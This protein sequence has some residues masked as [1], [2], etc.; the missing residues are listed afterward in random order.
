MSKRN[1]LKT[2]RERERESSLTKRGTA[3][4]AIVACLVAIALALT[5]AHFALGFN[6]NPFGKGVASAR[7]PISLTADS[8]EDAGE[9][10]KG[11]IVDFTLTAKY[12]AGDDDLSGL[13]TFTDVLPE[14]MELVTG[15]Q[16]V[17]GTEIDC[18]PSLSG[19]SLGKWAFSE[20]TSGPGS[21]DAGDFTYDATTRTLKCYIKDMVAVQDAEV[22]A[23]IKIYVKVT[24]DAYSLTPQL[25]LLY[26]TNYATVNCAQASALSNKIRFY[27]GYS[28]AGEYTLHY[29]WAGATGVG[30]ENEPP[31]GVTLPADVKYQ[32]S[33]D[34]PATAVAIAPALTHKG[35]RFEGW[36]IS[37]D[38]A[39]AG[40]TLT[41][42]GL[43]WPYTID[44]TEIT[45]VGKWTKITDT[46]KVENTWIGWD[47]T[48]G[49][50]SSA[51]RPG[52]TDVTGDDATE[53][54]VGSDVSIPTYPST[55]A[56]SSA[57]AGENDPYASLYDAYTFLGYTY[58]AAYTK[59]DV[60]TQV[61]IALT[62]LDKIA[63]TFAPAEET[64]AGIL[65]KVNIQGKWERKSFTMTFK[66]GAN[67]PSTLTLADF[68]GIAGGEDDATDENY[69]VTSKWGEKI[70]V[71]TAKEVEGGEFSHW[72]FA[73]DVQELT[74]L[75]AD[76]TAT[77]NMPQENVVVTGDWVKTHTLTTNNATFTVGTDATSKT[78]K[79]VAEG[80]FIT[81][82]PSEIGDVKFL[83]YTYNGT[84]DPSAAGSI[85]GEWAQDDSNTATFKMPDEDV[86]LTANMALK[87][88]FSIKNG[89]WTNGEKDDFELMLPV[90]KNATDNTWAGTLTQANVTATVGDVASATPDDSFDAD[91]SHWENETPG[92]TAFP[93][94]YLASD[95]FTADATGTFDP[96]K[97]RDFTFT[98]DMLEK[99]KVTYKVD[100]LCEGTGKVAKKTTDGS[101]PAWA[102]SWV[103]D[104]FPVKSTVENAAG[105]TTAKANTG[106]K[107]A[108]WVKETDW[109]TSVSDTPDF[110]PTKET[111]DSGEE[112][113]V[114]RT[115]C[116]LFSP[117]Q[118]TI[119]FDANGGTGQ[120][121]SQLMYYDD[122]VKISANAFTRDNY[123]F[124]G[125]NTESDGSGDCYADEQRVENL[126][127]EDGKEITLYAQWRQ[128]GN[129]E[130]VDE[131]HV[132]GNDIW[133]SV[134]EA[135]ELLDKT[136]AEK[137]AYVVDK[138][139]AFAIQRDNTA[140]VTKKVDITQADLTDV[141]A[142]I[143]D[144][145]AKLSTANTASA[146]IGVHVRTQTNVQEDENI[147]IVANNFRV[148]SAN[149]EKW[150]LNKG[151][152]LSDAGKQALIDFAKA[153]AWN[154]SDVN[155][156]YDIK[157]QDNKISS[158]PGVYDVTFK[159]ENGE[160]FTV[161]VCVQATVFDRSS[162]DEEDYNPED[163][164]YPHPQPSSP[165]DPDP[166][167]N[168]SDEIVVYANDFAISL[169]EASDLAGSGEVA[170][171]TVKERLVELAAAQAEWTSDRNDAEVAS[172]QSWIKAEKGVYVV[173][174][175]SEAD[176][177]GKTANV[178]VNAIVREAGGDNPDS[179]VDERITA[180]N[181]A[182]KKDDVPTFE[183]A[184]WID[185][186][187]A[188]A[189]KV[190]DLTGGRN[191]DITQVERQGD[192]AGSD[193]QIGDYSDALKFATEAGTS[194]EV[195]ARVFDEVEY[196]DPD[197][198]SASYVQIAANN[199]I[200]SKTQ[201]SYLGLD[202]NVSSMTNSA[203]E[204]LA[205]KARAS[206]W[207]TIDGTE[208]EPILTD[209]Q[210]KAEKGIY[211]VTFTAT[212]KDGARTA[213]VTVKAR[214]SDEDATRTSD[215]I[216]LYANNIFV[217]IPEVQE[218]DLAE[219]DG[220][221]SATGEKNL[222]EIAIAKAQRVADLKNIEVKVK[223]SDV[224]AEKGFY[225]VTFVAT[226]PDDPSISAEVTIVVTVLDSGTVEVEYGE[227]IA[228]NNFRIS[229]AEATS[230]MVGNVYD[231]SNIVRLA[232][233]E[234]DLN[235]GQKEL[236]R[237][238]NARA[239]STV[240]GA[241]VKIT[242]VENTLSASKGK[243]YTATF[244]TS[245]GTEVKEANVVV[246]DNSSESAELKTRMT[247][248]N[249]EL[250][251]DE[252][253]ELLAKEDAEIEEELIEKC[254]AYAYFTD[255]GAKTDV[256][257]VKWNIEQKEGAYT[258]TFYT[259]DE[260]EVT[261]TVN[262]GAKVVTPAVTESTQTPTTPSSLTKTGDAPWLL[263]IAVLV[264]TAMVALAKAFKEKGKHAKTGRRN[265]RTPAFVGA[266]A[267]AV[268]LLIGAGCFNLLSAN[269]NIADV[270]FDSVRL[271]VGASISLNGSHSVTAVTDDKV[272]ADETNG[273]DVLVA[274]TDDIVS[275]FAG[276]H[277]GTDALPSAFSS[278]SLLS[279]NYAD[280]YWGYF[281]TVD[282]SYWLADQ[283]SK[284]GVGIQACR[285]ASNG[286]ETLTK[287]AQGKSPDGTL[288]TPAPA[289]A[290]IGSHLDLINYK[291]AGYPLKSISLNGYDVKEDTQFEDCSWTSNTTV[292]QPDSS[293]SVETWVKEVSLSNVLYTGKEVYN[294]PYCIDDP[295]RGY[296]KTTIVKDDIN[297]I[298]KNYIAG[299]VELFDG[300]ETCDPEAFLATE[301]FNNLDAYIYDPIN[302][303]DVLFHDVFPGYLADTTGFLTDELSRGSNCKYYNVY[304]KAEESGT[305]NPHWVMYWQPWAKGWVNGTNHADDVKGLQVD[306]GSHSV[307]PSYDL[308]PNSIAFLRDSTSTQSLETSKTVGDVP[309][310]R[311][312]Y[313]DSVKSV[314]KSSN[315]QLSFDINSVNCST[316][317]DAGR[318]KCTVVDG[319]TIKVPW[320]SKELTLK[321]VTTENA[322]YI[323]ALVQTSSNKKYGVLAKADGT[324]VK[325]DLTNIL[326]TSTIGEKI[327]VSL[328]SELANDA[329]YSDL[330]S[331]TPVTFQIEVAPLAKQKIVYDINGGTG[332]VPADTVACAG[333][334][335]EI[336]DGSGLVSE[337]GDAFS[338]WELT[339]VPYGGT[340]STHVLHRSK[341]TFV[342]PDATGDATTGIITAKAIYSKVV[343]GKN[344]ES[345][346]KEYA[347][348]VF[349][350][351]QGSTF[352]ARIGSA[353]GDKTKS[354][355]LSRSEGKATF[356]DGDI[357]SVVNTTSGS[358]YHF[359]GW[360]TNKNAQR[361]DEGIFTKTQLKETDVTARFVT[362]Y[363]IWYDVTYATDFTESHYWLGTKDADEGYLSE[364]DFALTDEN[365]YSG[366]NIAS[367]MAVLHAGTG[368]AKYTE[369][370]EK[371]EAFYADDK[372][373]L[374]TNYAGGDTEPE[375]GESGTVSHPKNGLCEFRILEVSGVGGHL[376]KSGD[377]TSGDGSVVTFMTSH[378]LPKQYRMNSTDSNKGGWSNMELRSKLQKGGEIYSKFDSEFASKIKAVTKFNHPG[379]GKLGSESDLGTST[380]DYF[381]LPSIR[382]IASDTD[383]DL[384]EAGGL[385]AN[386]PTAEGTTYA[387]VLS[388]N[389]TVHDRRM[390]K[391]ST[392]S[393][394]CGN[395]N[396]WLRS[397][398]VSNTSWSPT[399]QWML[400][401]LSSGARFYGDATEN[402]F[403]A[404]CFCF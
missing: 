294:N 145:N 402:H 158:T 115:Y 159:A 106:Y 116:A 147:A 286:K 337:K 281:P 345:G 85:L 235:A 216:E 138:S 267:V 119:K 128:N 41:D 110:T 287:K 93:S 148:S 77:Y 246:A 203:K 78:T 103:T 226:D 156:A 123:V 187:R 340:E 400:G 44:G 89:T 218:K 135:K 15:T 275:S 63:G 279:E 363:A 164:P 6:L 75:K 375:P 4:S 371:W 305:V 346:G 205:E 270:A 228:S 139:H 387:W 173:K 143:G 62:D 230:I 223:S 336:A 277:Y 329:G 176:A 188:K 151:T 320:K 79:Q 211:D 339:Y 398:S 74:A 263:A 33:A 112:I 240:D 215:V 193:V 82:T 306:S 48:T 120:M 219:V 11:D 347:R 132:Y 177:N 131:T 385:F 397:P 241:V 253:G 161:S 42:A 102:D 105:T 9:V 220:K 343:A 71:P 334:Q 19:V 348:V 61:E 56:T 328:Y 194:V 248:N 27:S 171:N 292:W 113:W 152:N 199:F 264:I 57:D 162:D 142:K 118:Y 404:P 268:A 168:E 236:V 242:L 280:S 121:D 37:E 308:N 104:E 322:N 227:R 157:I 117:I 54:I 101:E 389:Y 155:A 403:I 28:E 214:V 234:V 25:K 262:V 333:S 284:Y 72:T 32:K 266:S 252:A 323:S 349:D 59:D 51:D 369:V 302:V 251:Y 401:I 174:F 285:T 146:T 201:V 295:S 353:T 172:A 313:N 133:L 296:Y 269:A 14:H 1:E 342:M 224:K 209:C 165:E 367:D 206:A 350:S 331:E 183:N 250:T 354:I 86:T 166:S 184:Q 360:S 326:S 16:T 34:I 394:T 380:N 125:W 160:T 68:P 373:R 273:E 208:I 95:Y 395:Q 370:L 64:E 231:D 180:N 84:S 2:E 154:T 200:V 124:A 388:N 178:C 391:L 65:T 60:D 69:V 382:E 384:V 185:L 111:L 197:D 359:I 300:N 108:K 12:S 196:D 293:N 127:S 291:S 316:D 364:I 304:F 335:V 259:E 318:N 24:D 229:T 81:V 352:E 324:D 301:S 288:F 23:S 232:S 35:Y 321:N 282:K 257:D 126:T 107:F 341:D 311:A 175:T 76:T 17:N 261:S 88:T 182:V 192:F 163:N 80:A 249:I 319:T 13:V 366:T 378:F 297:N 381:W 150:G 392:R 344:T 7:S 29:A 98:F 290:I 18:T 38:S 237:L 221:A 140:N 36:K 390:F 377:T 374:Y 137:L 327:T 195:D 170:S 49:A 298:F 310:A 20:A 368:N 255:T 254:D 26:Y 239:E 276:E 87:L 153:K 217:S 278:A 109:E 204:F 399:T 376:N 50:T 47:S 53:L 271:R 45:L 330:I 362:Y 317:R 167:T 3:P 97:I 307:R 39:I 31:T 213:S 189:V 122:P 100:V 372:V 10:Q 181:V 289:W 210:I 114:G 256:T 141:Q 309:K 338:R 202:A 40:V 67:W 245:F 198:W 325:L 99:V 30:E 361:G 43:V 222:V 21:A 244:K 332:T 129:T 134:A 247:S 351:N 186:A 274:E 73:P 314:V 190:K 8:T 83:N 46:F 169:E 365:Y 265:L 207:N 136:D 191:V 58:T 5:G 144:Y 356:S 70:V 299:R 225:N 91:A 272:F 396:W 66:K 149:V 383:T 312:Y 386:N 355:T 379:G 233:T 130:V 179:T 393:G 358:N 303:G 315:T 94:T 212:S 258:A 260:A 96:T 92:T 243:D 90:T 357:P 52:L 55:T 238:A 283:S 22:D